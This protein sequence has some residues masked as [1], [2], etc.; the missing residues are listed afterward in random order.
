MKTTP[1]SLARFLGVVTIF[2]I[3]MAISVTAAA[4]RDKKESDYVN[5]YCH[6]KT[7]YVL[8]DKTRV[9]CLTP[10]KAMEFDFAPKWAECVGQALYYGAMTGKTPTCVLILDDKN[11]VKYA[12]RIKTVARAYRHFNLRVEVIREGEKYCIVNCG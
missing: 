4:K 6:D 7:E 10:G 3:L 11:D 5:Q 12:K 8:D 1:N 9:D 2:G